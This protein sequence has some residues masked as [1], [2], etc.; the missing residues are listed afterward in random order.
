[1]SSA[2]YGFLWLLFRVLGS[3]C[4]RFKAVGSVPRTGG[5]LVASNHTSF[6]DIPL[7]GCGITRRVWFLG[8]HDLFPIPL[9]NGILQWLGW[10]PL[11]VGRLDRGAF[12][13]AA[14]LIKEGKAVAIFPEGTRSP[15]GVLRPGKPGI[16]LIVNQTGCAVVPAYV[17]GTY[18]ALP[19]GAFWPRF[20][21]VTVSYGEPMDFSAELQRME[22]KAFYQHVSRAVMSKIA[23][24]GHVPAPGHHSGQTG[25]HDTLNRK[26]TPESCNAE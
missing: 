11:R 10:I 6:L 5:V 4:F 9:L 2:I 18:E 8:R 13:K 16:G 26:F 23:E 24:L 14:S 3:I 7:L 20:P 25:R 22:G 17:S 15:N 21:R 19:V 1:M 12:G